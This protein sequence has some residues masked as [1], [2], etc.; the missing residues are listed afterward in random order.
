MSSSKE[1][2]ASLL[3]PQG[4]SDFAFDASFGWRGYNLRPLSVGIFDKA[5]SPQVISTLTSFPFSLYF[6]VFFFWW[7][8]YPISFLGGF[9]PQIFIRRFCLRLIFNELLVS[10]FFASGR[11]VCLLFVCSHMLFNQRLFWSA[12]L[13]QLHGETMVFKDTNPTCIDL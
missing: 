6:R 11:L 4:I 8:V 5:P 12:F 10:P 9:V 2:L 13:T 3:H 1:T 7:L